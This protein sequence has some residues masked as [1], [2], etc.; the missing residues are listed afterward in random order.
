MTVPSVVAGP[1]VEI[2]PRYTPP[3][4]GKSTETTQHGVFQ[5]CLYVSLSEHKYRHVSAACR[6][7]IDQAVYF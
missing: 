1:V 5:S 6:S 3:T 2:R 7:V 4:E